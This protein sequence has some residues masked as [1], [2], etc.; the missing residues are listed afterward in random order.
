MVKLYYIEDDSNI[1]GI[2]KEY[3]EQKNIQV[4]IYATLAQAGQALKEHVPSLVLL[5]W[6]MPD[7][8]GDGLCQWIRRNWKELPIIF[9]TV[10]GDSADI[11]SGFQNGADD[12]VVKP[13][14]L[15][16][17]HSRILALLRRTGHAAEQYLSCDGIGMDLNRH[18]V[19]L[20][21]KETK[22]IPSREIPLSE[23]EYQLLLY[24][25]QN[26]GKTVTREKILEQVWDVNGNFVNDN[27]LTVTMKRLRDKLC[28]PQCI[29]T[30]RSV[31][32]R[33]ED[34]L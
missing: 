21:S 32:Y 8:H 27:T 33:M 28:Q 1:A 34:T 4:T 18:T 22:E 14:E 25:M 30:V 6:N 15:E 2:V 11:V 17:L 19:S 23:A 3:L 12:Y 7:G 20:H 29:K 16:V 26:K 31:G 13:F 9:L 24:L 5:D 10:R